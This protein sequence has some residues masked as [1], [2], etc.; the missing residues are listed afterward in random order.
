MNIN[1][2]I[3]IVKRIQ[4]FIIKYPA[5]R[6]FEGRID[7]KGFMVQ[8]FQKYVED[9]K[10]CVPTNQLLVYSVT[11]GWEPLCNFLEVGVPNQPFPQVNTRG[12]FK[13]MVMKA[14]SGLKN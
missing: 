6:M 13:S 3:P 7:D 9:V 2:P 11:E 12:G 5:E 10:A 8:F 4:N 1:L 14:I